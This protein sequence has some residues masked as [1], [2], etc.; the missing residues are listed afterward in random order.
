MLFNDYKS[1]KK[2]SYGGQVPFMVKLI[3][4]SDT[5]A[6]TEILRI[7]PGKRIVCKAKLNDIDVI[8]KFFV[9]PVRSARHMARES[10]GLKTLHDACIPA[11]KLFAESAIEGSV[12]ILIT[13]YLSEAKSLYALLKVHDIEHQNIQLL[14]R[15]FALVA[16][17]HKAGVVQNDLHLDN[18]LL[19]GDV[20]YAIDAANLKKT[21]APLSAAA[22]VDNLALL[23]GQFDQ[24][25]YPGLL[26][27][28]ESYLNEDPYVDIDKRV[29]IALARL[30]RWQIWGKFRNKLLRDCSAIV[31]KSNFEQ[32]TLCKRKYYKNQFI[33]LINNPDAFIQ[34]APLLKDG[35]SSTVAL[36][37]IDGRK[38]AVKR[39]NIK[40]LAKLIRRQFS[41][42]RTR[43]NWLFGHMLAFW[44]FNTPEPIAMME[45]RLGPL[46]TSGYIVTE[47]IDA[48]NV[49]RALADA[50][51]NY[52]RQQEIMTYFISEIRKLHDYQI[53]H[54]DLKDTNFHY[55][56]SK[57]YIVDLDAMKLHKSGRTFKKA[58][59]KDLSRLVKNY[60]NHESLQDVVK[61]ILLNRD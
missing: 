55:A 6:C 13:E 11:P 59:Q 19:K 18:F 27:A 16:K 42:P 38:Y 44:G 1:L 14:K 41:T 49:R 33:D 47:F 4:C 15:F 21:T 23:L 53:T 52:Q 36:V 5:L 10:Q 45:K 9:D 40:N 25:Y 61:K 2:L 57:I 50:K 7:V 35:N 48:P 56:G 34:T 20:L 39:Y 46:R 3:N 29:V 28:L 31:R 60:Q 24:K 43:R 8:A 30:K 32:L 12:N 54:G 58:V 22:V 37:E 26:N 17:F 51:D